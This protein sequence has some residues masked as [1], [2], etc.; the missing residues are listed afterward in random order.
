LKLLQLNAWG[1]RLEYHIE[2]F[3]QREKPDIICLQESISFS[4][5][6]AG[7]FITLENIQKD[8]RL[9]FAAFGPV[10]SFNY[11][12]DKA[13]FG[14][15]ILSNQPII[16]KEIVFTHL[17]HQDDF[18]WG[19]HTSNMRNFVHA[20]IDVEGKPCNVITH[21]GYWVKAHKRGG[22]ETLRQMKI[23]ADYVKDLK[24]P[25]ILTGDFNL[26]PES[27]SLTELNSIL[28]NLTVKHKLKTTRTE[29][30]TK[31]EV[32]DYIFIND[33]VKVEEFAAREDNISDHQALVL[34]FDI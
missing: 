28:I 21:H 34:N 31:T 12:N 9:P 30:T 27:E 32:C 19:K 17:E 4:G 10:F 3:L 33:D 8:N 22:K 15:V 24:G 18:V 11:M 1:G 16:K 5:D 26:I 14:N 29:L 23:L 20:V 6:R 7:L 2:D 25:V 13:R